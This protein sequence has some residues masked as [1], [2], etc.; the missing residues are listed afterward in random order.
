MVML[1]PAQ[2]ALQ[3]MGDRVSITVITSSWLQVHGTLSWDSFQC[4][5]SG[6][7]GTAILGRPRHPSCHA[8]CSTVH[9]AGTW[10]CPRR[11]GHAFHEGPTTLL[12]PMPK[13]EPHPRDEQPSAGLT[14]VM[15]NPSRG[16]CASQVSAT[17][18]EGGTTA[19]GP[20]VKV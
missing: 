18:A 5:G 14:W 1:V 10:C 20:V 3:P 11:G 16:L 13:G 17:R 2:G 8:L 9:W 19:F 12:P 15:L 4:P 6:E 7:I